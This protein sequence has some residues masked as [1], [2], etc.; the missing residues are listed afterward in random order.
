MLIK[1]CRKHN[2]IFSYW[3]RDGNEETFGCRQCMAETLKDFQKEI[4]SKTR[5]TQFSNPDRAALIKVLYEMEDLKS[6]HASERNFRLDYSTFVTWQKVLLSF[7]PTC[8]DCRCPILDC[9]CELPW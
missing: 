1:W 8:P 5:V 4:D 3:Y 7:L 6:R 9:D 2:Q